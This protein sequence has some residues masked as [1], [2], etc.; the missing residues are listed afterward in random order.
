[1]Y[2]LVFLARASA[3]ML[4]IITSSAFFPDGHHHDQTSFNAA[5]S[6]LVMCYMTY[7]L[8]YHQ[9]QVQECRS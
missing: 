1:M 5:K 3:L 9:A 4:T 8:I 6:C 7:E 2:L